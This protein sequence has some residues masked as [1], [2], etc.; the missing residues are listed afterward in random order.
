M[1]RGIANIKSGN[2]I[3]A[4]FFVVVVYFSIRAPAI[5]TIV[6]FLCA[7]IFY[8]VSLCS[9]FY[10]LILNFPIEKLLNKFKYGFMMNGA[11]SVSMATL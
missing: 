10:A 3:F 6:H 4:T 9:G 2:S 11:D 1:H 7:L 8:L 5:A